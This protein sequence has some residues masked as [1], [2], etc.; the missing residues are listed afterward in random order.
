VASFEQDKVEYGE[1]GEHGETSQLQALGM[2]YNIYI[3]RWLF[4][5]NVTFTLQACF[6]VSA[7]LQNKHYSYKQVGERYTVLVGVA[8]P[9][10]GGL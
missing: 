6:M 10:Q 3:I 5:V 2:F 8:A 7:N 1:Y 4:Q 9:I